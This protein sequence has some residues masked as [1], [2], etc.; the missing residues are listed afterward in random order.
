M[1]EVTAL[2]AA[3]GT[4]ALPPI[5]AVKSVMGH[6]QA[7]AGSMSLLAAVLSLENSMLPPTA[8]LNE[9]DPALEGVDIVKDDGR[10]L[11][12]RNLMVNAFGFGGNNCV[13]IVTDLAGLSGRQEKG[14]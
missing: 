2:R 13:M 8:G 12:K 6:P 4:Q 10:S 14:W 9:I 11:S 1:A 7:G 3:F 5:T